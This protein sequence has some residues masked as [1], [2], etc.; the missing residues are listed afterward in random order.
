[1][2][3][4]RNRN[5]Y[6]AVIELIKPK[7]QALRGINCIEL[8]QENNIELVLELSDKLKEIYIE[9]RKNLDDYEGVSDILITKILM[10]TFGCV[11]AY[12]RFFV[13]MIRTYKIASGNFNRKS[14]NDLAEYYN[15][16]R[17]ALDIFKNLLSEQRGMHYP[18]MKIIDMAFWYMSYEKSQEKEQM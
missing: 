1:M 2:K 16:N 4:F 6:G 5:T 7:Y 14:L 18:E 3:A 11:P 17:V 13:D 10:G 15:D 8:L 12:Y 9:K